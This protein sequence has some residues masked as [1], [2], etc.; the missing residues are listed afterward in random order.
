MA[1][2]DQDFVTMEIAPNAGLAAIVPEATRKIGSLAM[3]IYMINGRRE[4]ARRGKKEVTMTARDEKSIE[5]YME[6]IESAE[7][8]I[9]RVAI[10]VSALAFLWIIVPGI[11]HILT[12]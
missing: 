8:I 5:R 10:I 12:H 3:R 1:I 2:A 4:I 6:H 7:Y 9:S 11:Y